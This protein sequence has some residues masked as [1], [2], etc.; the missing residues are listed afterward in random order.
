MAADWAIEAPARNRAALAEHF[1]KAKICVSGINQASTRQPSDL[2][3]GFTSP[4]AQSCWRSPSH[5][6]NIQAGV[7]Y[8]GPPGLD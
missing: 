5:S 2:I 8:P 3:R 4:L 7:T 1:C 6:M